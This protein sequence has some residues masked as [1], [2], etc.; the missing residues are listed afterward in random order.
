MRGKFVK[1]IIS[2]LA[3]AMLLS[4]TI[5]FAEPTKDVQIKQFSA[6]Q[7]VQAEPMSASEM[8]KVQGEGWRSKVVKF[9]WKLSSKL[10]CGTYGWACKA[11]SN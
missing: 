10:T 1:T 6:L 8:E 2:V 4:S 11:E 9:V 3:I 7:G 5:A